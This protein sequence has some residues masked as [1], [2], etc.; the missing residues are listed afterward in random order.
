VPVLTAAAW[1]LVGASSLLLGAALALARPW[2]RWAIGL[3]MAFG[4]GVLISSLAFDLVEEALARGGSAP[5]A[6]G[7]A[8]GALTYYVGDLLV[9]RRGAARAARR[10]GKDGDDDRGDDGGS[11]E[12]AA[13]I[14]VGAVL[15]GIPESAAIG[16]SLLDGGD[17]GLVFVA[18]VFLSNVPEALSA[19]AGLR[20]G[21]TAV[22][23][24]LGLWAVVVAVSTVAS[25]AGYG[26]LDGAGDGTIAGLSAYAG[27]AVLTMLASTMLPEA[28]HEGGRVTGLVTTA[29]FL[30]A[31]VLDTLA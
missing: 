22:R 14:V 26:L 3:V 12:G 8:A 1:G 29:G 24:I 25:A 13:G 23:R 5:T 27:G 4:S 18:A 28:H 7:I 19:S 11:G 2:P 31:V 17:V 15:D 6:I 16:I 9:D 10:R 21:G 20:A 30:L